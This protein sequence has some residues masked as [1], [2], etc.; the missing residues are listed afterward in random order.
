LNVE[1]NQR[2]IFDEQNAAPLSRNRRESDS[3]QIAKWI[4]SPA[5]FPGVVN[6]RTF[7]CESEVINSP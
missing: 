4:P 1:Q 7:A 5:D 3:A 2:D 6:E